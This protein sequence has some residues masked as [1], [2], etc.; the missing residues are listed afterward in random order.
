MHLSLVLCLSLI[1]SQVEATSQAK[2]TS[3]VGANSPDFPSYTVVYLDSRLS[4]G[5]SCIPTA[6]NNS[7]EIAGTISS[8]FPFAAF[9]D[10]TKCSIKPL[11]LVSRGEWQLGWQILNPIRRGGALAECI[12]EDGVV[13]GLIEVMPGIFHAGFWP[14]VKSRPVDLGTLGG[15]WSAAYGV[16]SKNIVVGQALNERN[17]N[18]AFV[19]KD[20]TMADLFP[21]SDWSLATSINE[22]DDI[23]GF[24]EAPNGNIEAFILSGLI[25]GS[26]EEC[27]LTYLGTLGGGYSFALDLNDKGDVVGTSYNSAGRRHA[28]IWRKDTGMVDLGVLDGGGDENDE[29]DKNEV[30]GENGEPAPESFATDV[31]N[32]GQVIGFTSN[33]GTSDEPCI[34]IKDSVRSINDCHGEPI[35]IE[36]VT[37][38]NDRG[39][40]CGIAKDESGSYRP[41]LLLP[42]PMDELDLPIQSEN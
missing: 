6:I 35:H 13:A 21:E 14:S 30:K 33:L 24:A 32:L 3:Q 39:E 31:N 15:T 17:L 36:L 37:G 34:W 4:E 26:P 29:K 23:A 16:N 28:F 1:S 27:S 41:I 5:E 7:G 19:W 2:I 20:G 22:D 10:S 42:L 11:K 18:H 38:I 9:L 25:D 12:S 8:P 40:I